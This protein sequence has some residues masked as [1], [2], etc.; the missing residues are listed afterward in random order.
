[1]RKSYSITILLGYL[2]FSLAC[3]N[4]IHMWLINKIFKNIFAS[5]A[6]ERF[7]YSKQ[8]LEELQQRWPRHE[9]F[10]EFVF[11]GQPQ[12]WNNLQCLYRLQKFHHSYRKYLFMFRCLFFGLHGLLFSKSKMEVKNGVLTIYK[13]ELNLCNQNC[14]DVKKC[15]KK[16]LAAVV[17]S[18]NTF[19]GCNIKGVSILY[20]LMFK[21]I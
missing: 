8:I 16:E 1:M 12:L 20:Y 4:E 5:F 3:V 7:W 13:G 14:E 18:I 2:G 6:I 21:N 17:L 11:Q 15:P 9:N 19:R 10:A